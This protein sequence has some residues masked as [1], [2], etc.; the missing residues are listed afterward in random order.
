MEQEEPTLKNIGKEFATP[1]YW[2]SARERQKAIK[3]G[4]D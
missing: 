4:R 3:T 2:A 1:G